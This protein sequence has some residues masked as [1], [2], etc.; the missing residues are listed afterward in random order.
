MASSHQ[1]KQMVGCFLAKKL[2][3]QMCLLCYMFLHPPAKWKNDYSGRCGRLKSKRKEP[4]SL[5]HPLEEHAAPRKPCTGLLNELELNYIAFMLL[6]ASI[7]PSNI[8][9]HTGCRTFF[10]QVST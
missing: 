5:N 8:G 1:L 3:M 9:L 4:E 6:A 10:L 2:K 7:M